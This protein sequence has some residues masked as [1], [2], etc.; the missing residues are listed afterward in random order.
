[1][2][3]ESIQSRIIHNT[4]LDA[5]SGN[6][7]I[8]KTEQPKVDK[9]NL[10]AAPGAP[11]EPPD[12][13]H[14]DPAKANKPSAK[15][16][17][18]IDRDFVSPEH[19]KAAMDLLPSLSKRMGRTGLT[20]FERYRVIHPDPVL[21]IVLNYF[22]DTRSYAGPRYRLK[23]EDV[24][25]IFKIDPNF[26]FQ[27][28]YGVEEFSEEGKF[29]LNFE[30]YLSFKDYDL[31]NVD[32]RSCLATRAIFE[33]VNLAGT[34]FSFS[35]F[36]AAQCARANL[37]E[38]NMSKADFNASRFNSAQM[39][40][41]D[42]S[43]SILEVCRFDKANASNANFAETKIENAVFKNAVLEGADFTKAVA[44]RPEWNRG[45]V[46]FQSAK[47]SNANFKD[48]IL[49]KANF[50]HVKGERCILSLASSAADK[51][52]LSELYLEHA[53]LQFS[54]IFLPLSAKDMI[55]GAGRDGAFDLPKVT[56]YLNETD[57][58]NST[59]VNLVM[60][61]NPNLHSTPDGLYYRA[62]GHSSYRNNV[63]LQGAY[64]RN[65]NFVNENAAREFLKVWACRYTPDVQW[66]KDFDPEEAG[67]IAIEITD[68]TDT[69]LRGHKFDKQFVIQTTI[70][71]TEEEIEQIKSIDLSNANCSGADFTDFHPYM[72]KCN[73]KGVNIHNAKGVH[74]YMILQ[75][76][77]GI[78]QRPILGLTD[79]KDTQEFLRNLKAGRTR[80]DD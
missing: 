43:Q 51:R 46:N 6:Q 10:H 60:F 47:L 25:N 24:K 72:T 42:L 49:S 29:L 55:E 35:R 73:W 79:E 71:K 62:E 16:V 3:L 31:S 64:L 14:N 44:F 78:P 28:R 2:S 58:A 8:K 50:E 22:Y 69:D 18:Y 59:I 40:H 68:W 66:P 70:N 36:G 39:Q 30:S 38:A 27:G 48:A 61:P 63:Y 1:M 37:Q 4:R 19:L 52:V 32:F 57:L 80:G 41:A 53:Q 17:T 34:D 23:Q 15:K 33:D 5:E 9:Q 77:V 21:N 76:T 54:Q 7:P 75:G 13:P 65:V 56:M 26:K 45:R 12:D 11:A 74:K 67:A 20:L